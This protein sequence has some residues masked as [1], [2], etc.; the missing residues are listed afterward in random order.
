MEELKLIIIFSIEESNKIQLID[1]RKI[2]YRCFKRKMLKLFYFARKY[3]SQLIFHFPFDILQ[4]N[5]GI[6]RR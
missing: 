5:M 6:L 4:F 1:L 3:I 2:N